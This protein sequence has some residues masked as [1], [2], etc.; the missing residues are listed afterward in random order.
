MQTHFFSLKD[1]GHLVFLLFVK[2]IR[3]KHLILKLSAIFDPY[4]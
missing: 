1:G 4:S 3:I 2:S